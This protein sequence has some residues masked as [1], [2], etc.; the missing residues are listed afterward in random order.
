MTTRLL[1]TYVQYTCVHHNDCIQHPEHAYSDWSDP[2]P[3][4]KVNCLL[5]IFNAKKVHVEQTSVVLNY[6][7][8]YSLTC[9]TIY[10]GPGI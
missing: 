7:S 3:P 5:L 6:W 8:G 2:G 9:L 10:S 4:S 1:P